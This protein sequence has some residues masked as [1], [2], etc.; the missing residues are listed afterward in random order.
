VAVAV[1]VIGGGGGIVV[2]AIQWRRSRSISHVQV[3]KKRRK[4]S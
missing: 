4:H 3:P 1:A 2:V